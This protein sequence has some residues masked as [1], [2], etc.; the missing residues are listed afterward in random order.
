MES[1]SLSRP[2]MDW[3]DVLSYTDHSG[4]LEENDLG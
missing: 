4:G 1:W 2:L 3:S